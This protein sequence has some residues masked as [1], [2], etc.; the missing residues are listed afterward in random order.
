MKEMDDAKLQLYD[1]LANC[2]NDAIKLVK[3]DIAQAKVRTHYHPE[4]IL[5]QSTKMNIKK[6]SE[7]KS[8]QLLEEFLTYEK[9][10]KVYERNLK[11]AFQ[12]EEKVLQCTFHF[13]FLLTLLFQL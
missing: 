9:V 13:W 4:F 7:L 1:K 11:L 10:Q 5:L 8:L 3:E 6:E 2:Y 12:I